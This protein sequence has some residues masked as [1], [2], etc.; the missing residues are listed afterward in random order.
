MI[1]LKMRYVFFI[2]IG[3]YVWAAYGSCHAQENI[4][5]AI[6][7]LRQAPFSNQDA[8]L[9]Y[10]HVA[11]RIS[12]EYVES[13]NNNKLLEGALNG[14]LQSL[15]PHSTYLDAEKLADIQ[16]HTHGEYGG[17]GLEITMEEGVVKI[18]S[19]IE[20]TPAF[21]AG[22]QTNDLI[23]MINDEPVYGMSII[24]A[25]DKMKGEPNTKVTLTIRRGNAAPFE[26]E[27]TREKI[28]VHPIKWRLEGEIGYLRITTFNERTAA[29]LKKA[30]H[31]VKAKLGGKLLGYVIDVRNNAG[32]LLD[33]AVEATDLFLDTGDIVS[34]RGRDAAKDFA[35]K[36]SKGDI[37]DGLPILVLINGGS[38]SA[39]EILAGALQDSKRALILG[40]KSFGKGSVQTIIPMTNGGAIKMTTALYYTPSGKSIQKTGIIPDVEIEQQIDMKS[41]NEEKRY[42]EANLHKALDTG[43][44]ID[45]LGIGHNRSVMTEKNKVVDEV[46]VAPT[47]KT[48][49]DIANDK[50]P[51][52]AMVK[53]KTKED[54]ILK[55]VKDYQ[56][57]QSLNVLRAIALEKKRNIEKCVNR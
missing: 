25:S 40:T 28:K 11:D 10:N 22:L 6:S 44:S 1:Y 16:N 20:D 36:A 21:K 27:I 33:Q 49:D 2:V 30:I 43:K 41:I 47:E 34:I 56:L 51:T 38:A 5:P 46:T 17:L 54:D 48:R 12:R 7:I 52:E 29:E 50:V 4:K 23:V 57:T 8:A 32:G 15:D 19:P 14:M 9:F 31:D 13:V 42:R 39:S 37:T 45:K 55:E 18:V 26:V 3:Q 53:G 24:A 35:F